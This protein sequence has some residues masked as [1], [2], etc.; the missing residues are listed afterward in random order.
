MIIYKRGQIYIITLHNDVKYR[1]WNTKMNVL[2]CTV[3][4]YAILCTVLTTIFKY[5]NIIFHKND[6]L[7]L[8]NFH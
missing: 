4:L 8:F 5:F 1:L 6:I 2:I 7:I 3:Y